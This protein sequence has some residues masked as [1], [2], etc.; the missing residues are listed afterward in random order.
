MSVSINTYRE[1]TH[2]PIVL[3]PLDAPSAA[4]EANHRIANNL[5][6]LLNLVAGEARAL[7]DAAGRAALE[8]TMNRL[9]AIAS[10]HRHL[11]TK[12]VDGTV[13]LGAY[14]RELC[15]HMQLSLPRHRTLLVAADRANASAETAAALGMLTAELVMNAC[16]HAYASDAPGAVAVSL[17]TSSGE[18]RL[19]VEDRGRGRPRLADGGGL[20]SRLIDAT[21]KRLKGLAVWEQAMPGTRFNLY[22]QL[23]AR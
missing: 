19:I 6:V 1:N 14:L 21:V 12:G 22:L 5:Q 8:R 3:P 15:A 17:S 20:G 2:T 23:D 11:H 9:T 13:D 10:V 4:D 18:A 7:E 16:K